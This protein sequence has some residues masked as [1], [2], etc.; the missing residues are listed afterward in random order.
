MLNFLLFLFVLYIIIINNTYVKLFI[1]FIKRNGLNCFSLF[2]DPLSVNICEVRN[3]P[4]LR[5]PYENSS[6][7][8][9]NHKI[10]QILSFPHNFYPLVRLYGLNTYFIITT[11]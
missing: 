3:Y 6:T 5:N 9:W 8:M 2:T 4:L 7:C 10:G 11:S 1:I